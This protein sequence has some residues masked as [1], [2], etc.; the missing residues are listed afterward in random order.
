MIDYLEYENGDEYQNAILKA[1]FLIHA[2]RKLGEAKMGDLFCKFVAVC[3]EKIA[4][5]LRE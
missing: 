2:V 1:K 3:R 4:E 5:E